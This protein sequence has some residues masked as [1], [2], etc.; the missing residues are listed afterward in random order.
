LDGADGALAYFRG[1]YCPDV[2]LMDMQMP[3]M[4]GVDLSRAIRAFPHAAKVPI[5]MVTSIGRREEEFPANLFRAFI[6][7]PIKASVL[8]NTLVSVFSEQAIPVTAL[9][10]R[11]VETLEADLAERLPLRI[12]LAEDNLVNQKLALRLLQRMG[13]RADLAAN[14]AEAI[15][16]LARQPYDLILMDMQMPEK[17]GL[18]ATREIRATL[19]EEAQPII[20]ALTANAMQGDREL[21]MAAGM[22]DY[23][24]KPIQIPELVAMIKKWGTR[25][26]A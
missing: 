23:L 22:N 1:G 20:V 14:G 4:D 13:Y 7:K 17:D 3:D 2:I 25:V 5:V 24:S 21:C 26:T 11:P 12:L 10:A 8:Y 16:A 19:S 18:E 6:N 9:P 15:A